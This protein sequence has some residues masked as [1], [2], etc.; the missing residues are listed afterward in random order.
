MGGCVDRKERN[1]L[2][3]NGPRQ[4]KGIHEDGRLSVLIL[5]YNSDE[6]VLADIESAA[7]YIETRLKAL[8]RL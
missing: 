3:A 5:Q 1:L 6:D 7:N 4:P 8:D 2:K